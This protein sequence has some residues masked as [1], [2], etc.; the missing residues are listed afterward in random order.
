MGL[1]KILDG[2]GQGRVKVIY[3]TGWFDEKWNLKALSLRLT[4]IR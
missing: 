1:A 3:F 4:T 2:T